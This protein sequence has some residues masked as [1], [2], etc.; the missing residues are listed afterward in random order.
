MPT[1]KKISPKKTS[2]KLTRSHHTGLLDPRIKRERGNRLL[3]VGLTVAIITFLAVAG[4]TYYMLFYQDPLAEEFTPEIIVPEETEIE[5]ATTTPT[6]TEVI[7][8]APVVQMVEILTTPTG[9][10]NVRQGPG[11]NTAK[12]GQVTPGQ[13]YELLSEDAAAGWYQIKVSATLSGWVTKQYAKI[14]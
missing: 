8:P 6:S 9:Y 11:T 10:L 2:V 12:V 14:K 4:L 3:K 1:S 5:E 13:S 7:A